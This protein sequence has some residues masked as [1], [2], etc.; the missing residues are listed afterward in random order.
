M[1][2]VQDA[3]RPPTDMYNTPPLSILILSLLASVVNSSSGKLSLCH[4]D[5]K[6][7]P[8]ILCGYIPI[9]KLFFLVFFGVFLPGAQHRDFEY[10]SLIFLLAFPFSLVY[11]SRAIFARGHAALF[12]LILKQKNMGEQLST[13]QKQQSF[14]SGDKFKI[15]KIRG[16]MAFSQK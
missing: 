3:C 7:E 16:F 11:I 13:T 1:C 9:I 2:G 12:I 6:I 4:H 14:V 5:F 8:V 15:K 10:S